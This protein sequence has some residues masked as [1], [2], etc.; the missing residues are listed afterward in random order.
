M[1][2]NAAS[3]SGAFIPPSARFDSI[4]DDALLTRKQLARA[5]TACGAPTSE[6]TL[7][8][9]ACRGNGSPYQ[10]YGKVAIYRWGTSVRWA[11]ARMGDPAPNASAHHENSLSKEAR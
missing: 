3:P 7:S 6:K 4:P 5:L 9:K 1:T 11:R 2:I 8:T 10:K